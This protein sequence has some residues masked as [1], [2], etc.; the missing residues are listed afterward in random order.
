MVFGRPFPD[1]YQLAIVDYGIGMT[2]VEIDSANETLRQHSDFDKISGRMLGFQVVARLA[3][4]LGVGVS[5]SPTAGATGVTAIVNLPS[6]IFEMA[7][8]DP[9]APPPAGASRVDLPPPSAERAAAMPA[10]VVPNAPVAPAVAAVHV[11]QV[12]NEEIWR[13]IGSAKDVVA[14]A[15]GVP[16]T[17]ETPAVQAP[18]HVPTAA[19]PAVASE[20][21]TPAV[22]PAASVPASEPAEPAPAVVPDASAGL[23]K[24]VRGAQLP[25]LGSVA[26][27]NSEWERPAEQVRSALASFQRGT[28]LGRQQ[29]EG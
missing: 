22:P 25:D 29:T 23:T 5:L 12:S 7:S 26:V 21:A 4:R 19:T 17:P 20:A 6:S 1:G 3:T 27:D 2:S 18:A 14:A 24:R 15:G 9:L 8:V 13:M 28:D 11:Q 16:H 10:P